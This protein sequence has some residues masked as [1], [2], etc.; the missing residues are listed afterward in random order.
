MKEYVRNTWKGTVTWAAGEQTQARYL[1]QNGANS[2]TTVTSTAGLGWKD[3]MT[4]DLRSCIWA[5]AHIYGKKTVHADTMTFTA[6]YTHAGMGIDALP[7]LAPQWADGHYN[8]YTWTMNVT[9]VRGNLPLPASRGGIHDSM[10]L[11]AE[12]SADLMFSCHEAT[13]MLNNITSGLVVPYNKLALSAWFTAGA[14]VLAGTNTWQ[15]TITLYA[16]R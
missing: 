9:P 3:F 13:P 7:A 8:P 15:L 5:G 1:V 11:N 14:T 16:C 10:G 6:R 4:L 2:F 12:S